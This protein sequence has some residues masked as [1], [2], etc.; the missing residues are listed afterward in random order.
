[1]PQKKTGLVVF[2]I[3]IVVIALAALFIW[4]DY[5][6]YVN[7]AKNEKFDQLEKAP[8]LYGKTEDGEEFELTTIGSSWV[9]NGERT[10][11]PVTAI[12]DVD[13]EYKETEERIFFLDD[14]IE[15]YAKENVNFTSK[16]ITE[17]YSTTG[18]NN[19]MKKGSNSW[20]SSHGNGI[21]VFMNQVG[22]NTVIV[23][24]VNDQGTVQALF[25]GRVLGKSNLFDYKD[26]SVANDK[27]IDMAMSNAPYSRF[28]K[29]Y[30]YKDDK[31]TIYYDMQMEE[32]M[33]ENIALSLM[34]VFK[35]LKEVEIKLDEATVKSV[36]TTAGEDK[37]IDEF[38]FTFTYDELNSDGTIDKIRERIAR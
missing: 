17:Y 4:T 3:V 22:K 8:I 9:Y 16:G 6:T 36:R 15:V 27:D 5:L 26:L 14:K 34:S 10:G 37:Y 18:L 33:Q 12:D 19:D 30:D 20:G 7:K 38:N 24:M 23:E 13:T 11:E 2:I 28:I 35:D 25:Y 1:M 29:K 21:D 32:Y 31:L